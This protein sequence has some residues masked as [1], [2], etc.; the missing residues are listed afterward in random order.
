MSFSQR[1]LRG[2]AIVL[3]LGMIIGSAGSTIILARS[4]NNQIDDI[5]ATYRVR[6]QAYVSL[7]LMAEA[8]NSQRGFI[9]TQSAP[10][11]DQYRNVT[12]R[13]DESLNTLT[14]MTK[15]NPRQQATA[16]RIRDLAKA[17]QRNVD[18]AISLALAGMNTQ[19]ARASLGS[20]F[21]VGQ[22]DEINKTVDSFLAEEDRRL[23]ERNIAVDRMRSW[24]TIAA[25]SSLGGA[26]ILAVILANRTRRYV[27]KLT[28]GQSLL[29]SEKTIL[30]SMVQDR[31]AE[32]EKAMLLAKRERARVE[33]LLQD[34]DHRIGNSLATVS[35][36]LGIQMR[37]VSSE[38]IR[39]AL[40]AARDRIQTIS[41][42]HR[43]LRLGKD[44]ETVRAD[45][46]LPDV[47]ADIKQSTAHD[48]DIRIAAQ[49]GPINL[50]SRDAT[51][52]G[53]IIGELT[54]NAIKHAFPGNRPGE[55]RI[56]LVRDEGDV[57]RLEIADTGIGMQKRSKKR[58]PGLGSLI[59][60]QLCQQFG[61]SVSYSVNPGGGTL[62]KV[63]LP[64]LMEV[65]P[66]EATEKDE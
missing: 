47:I 51:T 2:L 42:A 39:A 12:A 43:R 23:I 64:G 48:R 26:L 56:D 1:P 36:L 30:E 27:R 21:G 40:G 61:G 63:A 15:G 55:I 22:L 9:L 65:K 24:L 45:E 18:A 3:S 53:I 38:E 34:S 8:H 57:L 49:L 29:L 54:M 33:T 46:Y 6:E 19:A 25:L 28:E 5:L 52:L 17:K 20:N 7:S 16:T 13:L 44:H 35:S 37:D 58:S 50:S 41:S 11:L 32:L 62:V 14:E 60:D 10:L 59:V 66:Q 31:T 4:V